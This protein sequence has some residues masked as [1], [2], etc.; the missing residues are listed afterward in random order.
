MRCLA[1]NPDIRPAHSVTVRAE[2]FAAK[3]TAR[4]MAASEMTFDRYEV[5]ERLGTGSLGDVYRCRDHD[6]NFS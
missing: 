6:L 4:T 5:V 1:S 2:F 3:K